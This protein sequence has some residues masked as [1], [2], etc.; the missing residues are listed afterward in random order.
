[1]IQTPLLLRK[2]R[3]L[4]GFINAVKKQ[5]VNSDHV[6]SDFTSFLVMNVSDVRKQRSTDVI[7]TIKKTLN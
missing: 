3:V 1:M 6:V 4:V 5:A 2:D 7:G